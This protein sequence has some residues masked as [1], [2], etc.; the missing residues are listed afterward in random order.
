MIKKLLCLALICATTAMLGGCTLYSEPDSVGIVIGM[1]IQKSG[2]IFDVY[3]EIAALRGSDLEASAIIANGKAATMQDAATACEKFIG[4]PLYWAHLQA[5]ILAGEM[6]TQSVME[7]ADFIIT[8]NETPLSVR[9]IMAPETNA[10]QIWQNEDRGDKKVSDLKSF[11]LVKTLTSRI[12]NAPDAPFYKFYRD[13]KG[14]KKSALLPI[15]QDGKI[16]D[17]SY[18]VTPQK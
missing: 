9:L 6:P 2:D 16:T 13:I 12:T 5:I 14:K 10:E 11:A 15:L 3:C 7:V 17:H 8:D 4:K 18:K 1:S